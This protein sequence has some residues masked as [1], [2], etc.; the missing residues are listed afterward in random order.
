M[1]SFRKS[2]ISA[3][4]VNEG[5]V[6]AET[7]RTK[8]AVLSADEASRYALALDLLAVVECL[9]PLGAVL[10][11]RLA[12]GELAVERFDLRGPELEVTLVR[13]LITAESD[14]WRA[15]REHV[16]DLPVYRHVRHLARR[17]ARLAHW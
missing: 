13:L 16:Q 12:L 6:P 8:T 9:V 5:L 1:S 11:S 7:T 4:A 3:P 17:N 14:L 15:I 2:V 10:R